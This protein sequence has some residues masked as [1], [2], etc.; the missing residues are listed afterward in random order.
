MFARYVHASLGKMIVKEETWLAD[1]A[2]HEATSKY[3]DCLASVVLCVSL[4]EFN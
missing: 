3:G 4:K 1:L 2:R